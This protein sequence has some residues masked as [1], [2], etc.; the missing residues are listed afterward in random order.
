MWKLIILLVIVFV[1]FILL[2]NSP[3]KKSTHK[4]QNTEKKEHK[5]VKFQKEEISEIPKLLPEKPGYLISENHVFDF[6]DRELHLVLYARN[7]E[8]YVKGFW[9]IKNKNLWMTLPQMNADV[10]CSTIPKLKFVQKKGKMIAYTLENYLFVYEHV[11][12]DMVLYLSNNETLPFVTS[13]K[14]MKL[15]NSYIEINDKRY[16]FQKQRIKI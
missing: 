9:K 10:L 3:F 11:K 1:L 14:E 12:D 6:N 15:L 5:K 13:I 7:F 8:S 2:V 16:N 4:N